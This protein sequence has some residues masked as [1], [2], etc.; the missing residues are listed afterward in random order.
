MKQKQPPE[1]FC[2]KRCFLKF[3]KIQRENTCV[4]VSFLIKLQAKACNF[5]KKRLWYRSF[6]VNFSKFAKN[7]FF[8]EHLCATVSEP[9]RC[10]L[11]YT[12]SEYL[13][14]EN[15]NNKK[16]EWSKSTLTYTLSWKFFWEHHNIIALEDNP[17][18]FFDFIDTQSNFMS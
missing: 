9:F 5:I 12:Y 14:Y 2:K 11:K 8:T 16:Q 4:R 7:I 15:K 1:V 6:S 18:T 17:Q 10:A 13:K 3:R